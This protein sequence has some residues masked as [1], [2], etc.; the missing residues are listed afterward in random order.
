MTAVYRTADQ[1]DAIML[2]LAN[3]FPF[4]CERRELPHGTEGG[5]SVYALKIASGGGSGRRAF[6]AVGGM[7]AREYMNPDAI[8]ADAGDLVQ[9]VAARP[10]HHLPRLP[11]HPGGAWKAQ[12]SG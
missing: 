10:E 4:L 1:I 3:H 9:L 8:M 2:H 11:L 5:R 12:A 6:L 7:H